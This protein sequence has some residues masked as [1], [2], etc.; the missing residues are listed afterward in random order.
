MNMLIHVFDSKKQKAVLAG[1]FVRDTLT[2]WRK[3]SPKHYMVMY[4][5]YGFQTEL[6]KILE[7]LVCKTI[8]LVS[9][10]KILEFD[11]SD[12]KKYK[13]KDV[14]HGLQYFIPVASMR[15]M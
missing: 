1:E 7:P 10:T 3:V 2:F 8:K 9:K 14:G 13:P 6:L 15:T 4:R 12:F 11:F 5:G